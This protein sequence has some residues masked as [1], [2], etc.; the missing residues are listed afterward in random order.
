[1]KL[2]LETPAIDDRPVFVAGPF[3]NW[4][5]ADD[6]FRM[7]RTDAGRYEL[8]MPR[9]LALPSEYK[10][11]KGG[12][13]DVELDENGLPP[14]NRQLARRLATRYDYVPHWRFDGHD[15]HPQAWPQRVVWEG[16]SMWPFRRQRRIVILLP[17]EYSDPH[18]RFPVLYLKDG[19][20]LHSG[21]SHYGDWAVDRKMA[22]RSMQGRPPFI[23]VSIDH[24][25]HRRKAEFNPYPQ[26]WLGRSEGDNY[27]RF[28]VERLK[29]LVDE[30]FRTL[31]GRAHTGIGGSS[32]GG[33]I[34]LYLGMKYQEVFG[35]ML[36]FSP[37]LWV[38]GH[39]YEQADAYWPPH[40]TQIY[41]YAGGK[42]GARLPVATE[43]MAHRLRKWQCH[44]HYAFNP[45][46][47][48]TEADWSRELPSALRYLFG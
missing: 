9:G 25:E 11:T 41:L 47:R 38:S 34:S 22:V 43:H 36:I 4:Y 26:S 23:V 19:Q 12:W 48:H 30:N 8:K 44:V 15:I 1:M 46:G 33:L 6:R 10:Y 40:D 35:K 20:N 2:V 37:S 29:P 39:I 27:G 18:R 21:G 7:Q 42:E 32:L 31:P 13:T 24:G 3:N 17:A 14:F 16:V 5:P 45:R 28:V